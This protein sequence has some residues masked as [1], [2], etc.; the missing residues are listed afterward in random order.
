[1]KDEKSY[2]EECAEMIIQKMRDVA[3]HDFNKMGESPLDDMEALCKG[4]IAIKKL[5]NEQSPTFEIDNDAGR[6][7]IE[8]R[9][10]QLRKKAKANA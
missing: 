7:V 6:L 1:M 10:R 5:L 2:K 4:A 9:L 8:N 3:K